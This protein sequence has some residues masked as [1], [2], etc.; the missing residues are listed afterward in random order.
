MEVRLADA[1]KRARENGWIILLFQHEPTGTY[2]SADKAVIPYDYK[3]GVSTD[4]VGPDNY[5]FTNNGD[6]VTPRVH[7]SYNDN[8]TPNDTPLK[9]YNL[10]R[11]NPDIVRG[12]FTGHHHQAVYLEII[13]LD[14][15]G[16]PY[17]P[18]AE[19]IE[20]KDLTVDENG[21]AIIPQY[22]NRATSHNG[23]YGVVTK[24]VVTPAE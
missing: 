20:A 23:A 4:A 19:E 24:V 13:A 5:F 15:N 2:D 6:G 14:E 9:V 11:S 16:D 22:V 12:I 8:T 7:N 17:K 10:I 18:T 21:Y 3:G 1:I